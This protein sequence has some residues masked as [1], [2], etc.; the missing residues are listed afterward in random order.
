[1]AIELNNDQLDAIVRM[2][3][4]CV[5]VGGV[6]S[7]KSRTALGYFVLRVCKGKLRINN[8]GG[9]SPMKR[10]RNL[11]IITT[12]RK[13][14]TL[15]WQEEC[16]PFL[17]PN[18]NVTVTVD[19][20][21]NIGKYQNIK[22]SF[23]IFDEQRVIGSGTW[24]KMFYKICKKNEW[25]LLSATPGDTWMDYIPMFVANGFFKNKTEF[26][27][28]HVIFSR[29]SKF[30]KVDRYIGV[31]KLLRLRDTV[32]IKMASKR[33]TT[34]HH[35]TI[36]T[37]FDKTLVDKITI[38]R[39]NPWK[40]SPIATVGEQCYLLRKA[41]NSSQDRIRAIKDLSEKHNRLIIFYNF[42][43]ELDLLRQMAK[44]LKI[45]ST[46]WNGHRH[47]EYP[48]CKKWMYFVQYAAGA[49][50]WECIDTDTTVFYSQNYSYKINVQAAGRTDRM[51]TTFTDL[52]FYHIISNSA[53]D[54]AIQK[55]IKNKKNFNERKFLNI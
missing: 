51:N 54:L 40:E 39:W 12:A 43:Y 45:V 6:G 2:K 35:I 31:T 55:S 30:P 41:V 20:W 48:T 24:V 7:G 15:D 11:V 44:D 18:E 3:T 23:F 14:D 27:R 53:I 46:E 52:F 17:I 8:L 49:E 5:L 10:P 42:N 33:K 28:E 34:S 9:Y 16:V 4:G 50:A 21:N 25:V 29:F 36:L 47:E 26:V 37:S 32:T 22:D 1:M 13:R 38:D 19:S